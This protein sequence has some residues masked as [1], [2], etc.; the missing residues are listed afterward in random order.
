MSLSGFLISSRLLEEYDQRGRI[1]W[2]DFYVGRVF[3]I[4][5]PAFCVLAAVTLLG[6]LHVIP[7]MDEL[8][9]SAFFYR[10]HAVATDWY[11]AHFWSLAVEEQ[12]YL[13]W[14]AILCAAGGMHWTTG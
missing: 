5:P 10:N 6:E 1:R 14:P 3:R 2:A 9:P 12:F 4:L 7:M 13:P 11:A 8:L